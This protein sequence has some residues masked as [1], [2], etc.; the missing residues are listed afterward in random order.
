[1]KIAV[2]GKGNAGGGLADLW[3]G[4]GHQVILIGRAGGDVSDAEVILLAVPGDRVAEA[5]GKLKGID[6]KPV[7]D[8][9]NLINAKPPAGFASNAEFVKSK[10]NGPTAKAFNINFAKLY[11]RVANARVKPSN[12]W[13]GDNEVRAVVEQLSRDAGFEPV[14]MGPL[15]NAA[16][17]ERLIGPVFA[18]AQSGTGPFVYRITN[19]EEL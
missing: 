1:M 10:T 14:S 12:L 4:K 6:R 8:A 17:Q 7:I 13:S 9:T 18:I 15:S 16:L 11:D 3:K 2:Y 19:P 5:L